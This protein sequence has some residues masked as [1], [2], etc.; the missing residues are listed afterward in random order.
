VFHPEKRERRRARLTG[1]AEF[2]D[3]RPDRLRQFIVQYSQTQA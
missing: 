2:L 1:R 3:S